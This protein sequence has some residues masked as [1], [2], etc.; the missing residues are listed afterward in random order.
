MLELPKDIQRRYMEDTNLENDVMNLLAKLIKRNRELS[1]RVTELEET[2][3]SMASESMSKKMTFALPNT[4]PGLSPPY[5]INPIAEGTVW[6]T[7]DC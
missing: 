2:I 3:K 1:A 4:S 6:G 7:N 5:T